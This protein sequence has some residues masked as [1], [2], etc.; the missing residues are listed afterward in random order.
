ME[1]WNNE[2]LLGRFATEYNSSHQ[3]PVARNAVYLHKSI[4]G[5]I[6]CP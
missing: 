5:R 6:H 3:A 1:Q 4:R 2:L